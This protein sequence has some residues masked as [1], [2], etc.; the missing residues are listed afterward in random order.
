MGL[1]GMK[2]L[3]E[4]WQKLVDEREGVLRDVHAR[5]I[6][7][8][9]WNRLER[10]YAVRVHEALTRLKHAQARTFCR[11]MVGRCGN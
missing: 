1:T 11:E 10:T 8:M 4:E 9:E 6:S 7:F 5:K 2:L 3:H